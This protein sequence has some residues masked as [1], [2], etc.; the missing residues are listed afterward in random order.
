MNEQALKDRLQTISKEKG[1]HFNECWKK[2]LLERFLSRL[3]QSTHSQKFIFKGGFLLSYIMEIG[4]ETTDLDFLLTN[5]N[6]SENEIKQ[7]IQDVIA[8]ESAAM[9]RISSEML[10]F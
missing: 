8:I 7:T 9:F 6:A 2:L 1:I 4:R 3:S 10:Q 5:M